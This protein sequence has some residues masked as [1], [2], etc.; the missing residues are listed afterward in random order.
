[1]ARNHTPRGAG[2]RR[3]TMNRLVKILRALADWVEFHSGR[4]L[5]YGACYQVRATAQGKLAHILP[6]GATD[7]PSR[8][9]CGRAPANLP[10]AR[11]FGPA[12]RSERRKVSS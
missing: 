9:L 10:G 4:S 7:Y 8:A 5:T 6:L 2:R 11:W 12:S 3:G 1:M